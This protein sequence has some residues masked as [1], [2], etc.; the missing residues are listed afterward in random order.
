MTKLDNS[1][2][3]NH[4]YNAFVFVVILNKDLTRAAEKKTIK[5][6]LRKIVIKNQSTAVI[7]LRPLKN[8]VEISLSINKFNGVL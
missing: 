1:V 5:Y 4:F 8:I 7:K 6:F 2:T 3:S